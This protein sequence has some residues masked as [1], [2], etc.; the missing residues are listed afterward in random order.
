MMQ[1]KIFICVAKESYEVVSDIE[2]FYN[3]PTNTA[4]FSLW[5]ASNYQNLSGSTDYEEE[6]KKQI[7]E[8][9]GAI[10]LI[11]K[12]SLKDDGFIKRI[13]VPKIIQRKNDSPEYGIAAVVLD[14]CK[15]QEDEIFGKMQ[16]INSPSS[17]LNNLSLKQ[18]E[19][20]I[21][22]I[23]H[24][25]GEQML[26]KEE[27]PEVEGKQDVYFDERRIYSDDL[28]SFTNVDNFDTWYVPGGASLRS[29]IIEYQDEKENFFKESS[30]KRLFS[31]Y[32]IGVPK[33]FQKTDFTQQEKAGLISL[34]KIMQR[35][36]STPLDPI[37]ERELL[38]SH[39]YEVTKTTLPGNLTVEFEKPIYKLTN[40]DNIFF[41]N[42]NKSPQTRID[43]AGWGTREYA[44]DSKEEL[45]FYKFIKKNNPS[46]IKWLH[47][48]FPRKLLSK[49]GSS[50]GRE[51]VDFLYSPP[52]SNPLIIEILGE[53]HFDVAKG[54]NIRKPET[55]SSFKKD[56][57]NLEHEVL[58]IPAFE[59]REMKGENWDKVLEKMKIP[60][61]NADKKLVKLLK[62]LWSI[63]AVHS[64]IYELFQS[65]KFYE[66]KVWTILVDGNLQGLI[67]IKRLFDLIAS[68]TSLWQTT[69]MLPEQ[70]FF[71]NNKNEILEQLEMHSDNFG[72]VSSKSDKILKDYDIS[73][74]IDPDSSYLEEFGN[75]DKD[76]ILI[77]KVS[78]PFLIK[79]ERQQNT[80]DVL[81]LDPSDNMGPALKIILQYIFAKEDFREM[82]LEAITKSLTGES[83]LVLLPTG[84]GKSLIYQLSAILLPGPVIVI[85]PTVQLINN[86]KVN[87]NENGIDRVIGISGEAAP[88]PEIRERFMNSIANGDNFIILCAPER[89]LM[90]A[91]NNALSSVIRKTGISLVVIDEAHC[92]SEWG[93]E[94]R[95]S[96]LSIG[97]RLQNLINSYGISKKKSRIPLLAMTGTAS[98]AVRDDILV[99]CELSENQELRAQKF[100]R[101]ELD[102]NVVSN[103]DPS[104]GLTRLLDIVEYDIPEKFST[105]ALK[106][107]KTQDKE[108][109]NNLVII[110]VQTK[111]QLLNVYD[112]L[113][114]N[115]NLQNAKIGMVW[116]SGPYDKPGQNKWD[117][118]KF[119]NSEEYKKK[120]VEEFKKGEK[121]IIIATKAFG[122]G[123]DIPNVRGVIHFGIAS[124]VES[125]Y[126]ESG[127]A[128]RDGKN[129]LCS[130]IFTE[131]DKDNTQE[132]FSG[133]YQDLLKKYQQ[134]PPTNYQDRDDIDSHLWFYFGSWKG[135]L[136]ELIT[137]CSVLSRFDQNLDFERRQWVNI[138]FKEGKNSSF[139][140]GDE[141]KAI[142]RL[143]TMGLFE[144]WQMDYAN[145]SYKLR[146]SRKENILLFEELSKWMSKRL[147]S[148]T[149]GFIKIIKNISLK[150]N[151]LT[152]EEVINE[153]I[154]KLG[155]AE[156]KSTKE[157]SEELNELNFTFS[158]L[159][160]FKKATREARTKKRASQKQIDYIYSLLDKKRL[161]E[162]YKE[163]VE[164]P[165]LDSKTASEL[166][167]FLKE[168]SVRNASED[169]KKL[170]E[171]NL[172]NLQNHNRRSSYESKMQSDL[173]M[174]E[175]SYLI[176][177]TFSEINAR[178]PQR[179]LDEAKNYFQNMNTFDTFI[180]CIYMYL[181][182]A[183]YES[184]GYSRRQKHLQVY[185]LARENK[186]NDEI[187]EAFDNYFSDSDSEFANQ[188]RTQLMKDGDDISLWINTVATYPSIENVR[189][190]LE[191]IREQ[192]DQFKGW[193]WA[194][195]YTLLKEEDYGDRLSIQYNL[196]EEFYESKNLEADNL[197][198]EIEIFIHDYFEKDINA[199][200]SVFNWITEK[201]QSKKTNFE[202]SLGSLILE[203]FKTEEDENNEE[204]LLALMNN[205]INDIRK[206]S[207]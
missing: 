131:N 117:E 49:A 152:S 200:S 41:N 11:S 78:L 90:P 39:G 171:K 43:Y 84:A 91:F 9:S 169:Q 62:D 146:T 10:I 144:D 206:I 178:A 202:T 66:K 166:I 176:A 40:D 147:P 98:L 160:Q 32:C 167:G 68:I 188:M 119:G 51:G 174:K 71:I 195:L 1:K 101:P 53:Q 120:C 88:N 36:D 106:F 76:T 95:T 114:N 198:Q 46:C 193:H 204:V 22:R 196:M 37:I 203:T 59:V 165:Y 182:H 31:Q 157:S 177:H 139:G 24:E 65:E 85:D 21:I 13:E 38:Q 56:E 126:Q 5:S 113:N 93:Q 110:F 130:T 73:L 155:D 103:D 133:N 164:S 112:A 153:F 64:A 183:T 127:R 173:S 69:N 148:S 156:N 42:E 61:D 191:K 163:E 116:G 122:M 8:S 82:Q 33:K 58:G 6:I 44:F 151:D 190:E 3:T 16:L 187:Q 50:E 189:L 201:P 2:K 123:I 170:L 23:F 67:G 72:Y 4:F 18:R 14:D 107:Y 17:R 30:Y 99:E 92:I 194:M 125:W 25:L 75:Y 34:K 207:N 28:N 57:K 143:L 100:N 185:E 159:N 192:S 19:N 47:P 175:A 168:N 89:L 87:L 45:D 77:K 140:D 149:K 184:I 134:R 105:S 102:F 29:N 205:L 145:K 135:L 115:D 96:Y 70:V 15:F 80:R 54:E 55:S 111:P 180:V 137:L 97:K 94:F 48:Q 74:K 136:N 81:T 129:A 118:Y 35:G 181:V 141:T 26:P 63:G 142:Y 161:T 158:S 172:S 7:S 186:T 109:Q 79:D 121:N 27:S 132:L 108:V 199:L 179:E 104:Q 60:N 138:D 86:Q 128:G 52:W 12:G 20:N 154:N 197:Y 124:S 150:I 162:E 83:S